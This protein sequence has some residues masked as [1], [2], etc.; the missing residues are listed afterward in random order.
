MTVAISKATKAQLRAA[1]TNYPPQVAQLY[2][3]TGGVTERTRQLAAEI[4]DTAEATTRS[5]R[6]TP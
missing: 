2:L 3:G 5:T 1:G 6:L 4:V